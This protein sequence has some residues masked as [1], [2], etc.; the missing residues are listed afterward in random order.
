MAY[1]DNTMPDSASEPLEPHRSSQPV[2]H[3]AHRHITQE[4]IEDAAIPYATVERYR[5]LDA[6]RPH[7]RHMGTA[8]SDAEY[9][10]HQP[11]RNSRSYGHTD[12][13]HHRVSTIHSGRYLQTPSSGK[14]IFTARHDRWRR[15]TTLLISILIVASILLALLWFFFLR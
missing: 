13:H 9:I 15:R 14:T 12:E 4:P 6:K 5:S 2:A 10:E 3:N 8:S 11:H 1:R 7:R